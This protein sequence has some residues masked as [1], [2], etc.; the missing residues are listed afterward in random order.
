MMIV[1][2]TAQAHGMGIADMDDEFGDG[3]EV[4]GQD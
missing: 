2:V 1:N 4:M 3:S